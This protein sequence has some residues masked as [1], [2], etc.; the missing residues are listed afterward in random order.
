METQKCRQCKRLLPIQNFFFNDKEH[1][2]CLPC[3][4]SRKKNRKDICELCQTR[5]SF[6]FE[7]EIKG[8]RC[9]KHKEIGMIDVKHPKCIICKKTLPTF[10]YEEDNNATHCKK[11][12][13]PS[14]TDLK[15]PKCI[16]C[17]ITQPHYGYEIDKKKTHCAKCCLPTMIELSN[18]KCIKCKKTQPHYGYQGDKATHC[19]K[20]S[21]PTMIDLKNPKCTI[22]DTRASY[23]LPLNR[24][25]RCSSHKEHGMIQNPR[26][27]CSNIGCT[28][29]S[30]YGLTTPIHCEEH[31][32]SNDIIL[33]ERTCKKCGK[34]DIVNHEGICMNFCLL[35][36]EGLKQYQ[37][38]Q[39][40]KEE[41]IVNLLTKQFGKP[42]VQ[43]KIIDSDCGKERPDIVY[44]C[45]THV[46]VIEVDERQHKGYEC[47]RNTQGEIERMINIYMA[48]GYEKVFFIRYNPDSYKV[49]DKVVKTPNSVREDV[50]VK[51]ISKLMR[52]HDLPNLGVM[53]LYYDE[54]VSTDQDYYE[55][56]DI[57]GKKPK[58]V[59][60]NF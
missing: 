19:K 42:D 49:N 43:N 14:M 47:K 38:R 51:W 15:H 44:D 37:K 48:L 18:S 6:N 46:L 52:K 17:K 54:Y 50:L 20:C 57:Y 11:C 45:K 32:N 7:G 60:K 30:M 40:L 36:T 22:C 13:L 26:K 56:K 4:E 59:N 41:R 35:E 39:K 21:S 16:L 34:I 2:T 29:Y 23:G 24:P 10:G 1:K 25:S 55:I 5:A 53:Y 8:I 27:K 12:S 31:K 3:A 28:N 58:L 33:V 9:S